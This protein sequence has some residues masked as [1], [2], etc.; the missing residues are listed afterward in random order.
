MQL[1]GRLCSQNT[2][3]RSTITEYPFFWMVLFCCA[4]IGTGIGGCAVNPVTGER[5]L[6]LVSQAS[7]INLGR[8]NYLPAQQ[9]QGGKLNTY[10]EVGNYVST[11]GKRLA[12]ISD[13]PDLPYEF[14]VLNNSVPNAWALP[15][16]KIAINRGLLVELENEAELAA[17]LGH[18]IVHAA[19][20]HGAKGV[21]RGMILQA[22]A[23]GVGVAAAD[24][25]YADLLV[26]SAAVGLGLINQKYSRAH[27]L[28]ADHYGMIYMSKAGYEP[29]AAVTLQ[30]KFVRLSGQRRPNWLQGL[31]ASHP[32]SQERVNKNARMRQDLPSGGV[33]GQEEYRK[34]MAAIFKTKDAYANYDKGLQAIS[35]GQASQAM[36]FA[37]RA[38]ALEPKESFFHGLRG[39]ALL[40]QNKPQQ[41][42]SAYNKAVALNSGYYSWYSRR[43]IIQQQLGMEAA[44]I[45]DLQK[46]NALLP[47]ANA[48]YA[49]GELFL[50]SGQHSK[51]IEHLN[52][53]ASS[54]SELGKKA[55]VILAQ[56][57]LPKK[58]H[59]YL[60]AA[61]KMD[62]G[63]QTFIQVQNR[64]PVQVRDI[65]VQVESLNSSGKVYN[66]DVVK[67]PG[68]I[69]PM[70]SYSAP[71]R[72]SRE[73]EQYPV[74]IKAKVLSAA[75]AK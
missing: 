18:E 72:I 25:K 24:S 26:G 47:T 22:G 30:Q 21:E 56:L 73:S 54:E 36:E 1:I 5:E 71:V 59:K 60:A 66:R 4:I 8:E 52:V 67:I 6:H 75:I 27:E 31:F 32:P 39:E 48:N 55:G 70:G 19:A 16:G 74:R 49:L 58:P 29:N 15:G 61:V 37:N 46:S 11:I 12:K 10:P 43:G 68:P 28:E 65:T 23:M 34:T 3:K 64:A 38:L 2:E 63:G 44:A 51:A 40:L 20:R 62:K 53:A 50:H 13:R 42:L 57:E 35:K 9:S 69:K 41:A 7:E 45:R 17:V 33:V 14:V